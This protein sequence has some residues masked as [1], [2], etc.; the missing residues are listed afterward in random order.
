MTVPISAFVSGHF[1]SGTSGSLGSVAHMGWPST[2][3]QPQRLLHG[4]SAAP[5]SE[6]W[7][8]AQTESSVDAPSVEQEPP[9]ALPGV[10]PHV[11]VLMTPASLKCVFSPTAAP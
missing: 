7:S 2:A 6:P 5:H 9:G 10:A 1:G 11:G 3:P 8:I 4:S